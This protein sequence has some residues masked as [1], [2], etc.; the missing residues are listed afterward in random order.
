[1]EYTCRGGE[2]LVKV[3]KKKLDEKHTIRKFS[4]PQINTSGIFFHLRVWPTSC[5][6]KLWSVFCGGLLWTVSG[7][8]LRA[9]CAINQAHPGAFYQAGNWS[10]GAVLYIEGRPSLL[11]DN[12]R[13]PSV[14]LVGGGRWGLPNSNTA[15]SYH[16]LQYQS[17]SVLLGQ[18][19]NPLCWEFSS[20]CIQLVKS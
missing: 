1:M 20:R 13:E 14:V 16:H 9:I 2:G 7:L 6:S 12:S 10:R 18:S 19:G 15:E 5:L 3:W 17:P 8:V 4:E 11:P